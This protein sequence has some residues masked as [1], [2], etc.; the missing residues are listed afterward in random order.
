MHTNAIIIP[1]SIRLVSFSSGIITLR[2][3]FL[4]VIISLVI[5]LTMF[6]YTTF[7]FPVNNYIELLNKTSGSKPSLFKV[8]Y[9]GKVTTN[10]EPVSLLLFTAIVPP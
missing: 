9:L 10:S 8:N 7:I 5:F 3:Q 2:I 1:P 6:Y 4:F